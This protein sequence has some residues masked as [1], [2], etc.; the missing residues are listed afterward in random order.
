MSAAAFTTYESA[1]HNRYI[2]LSIHGVHVNQR[3]QCLAGLATSL[4]ALQTA[5]R[6]L[7]G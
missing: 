5:K 4:T 7:Q 3:D 6:R 2:C 1:N